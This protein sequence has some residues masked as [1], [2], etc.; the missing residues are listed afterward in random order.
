[1]ANRNVGFLEVRKIVEKFRNPGGRTLLSLQVLKASEG[2]LNLMR[3]TSPFSK[4][5]EEEGS[6]IT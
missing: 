1:M 5:R 6:G 3:V 4:R 2:T